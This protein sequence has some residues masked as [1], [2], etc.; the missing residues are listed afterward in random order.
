MRIRDTLVWAA[1][2]AAFGTVLAPAAPISAEPAHA[3]RTVGK[4]AREVDRRLASE[5]HK[6][7]ADLAPAAADAT[8]LRRV[9]LDTVGD[10]PSPEHATAFV[11]DPDPK[12]RERVLAELVAN[13]QFGHN[14]ARY[15]RDVVL[16]RRVEERAVLAADSVTAWLTEEINEGS[17]WDKVARDFITC[18]GDVRE[19]GATAIV[20][21]QDGRTEETTA[22]IARIFLG[23]QIQCAQCH[24]H[25]YDRWSRE[26]FHELAAFFPRTTLRQVVS[27]TKRSFEVGFND[28]PRIR[29]KG[30]NANRTGAPE[31][32]M[33][34]LDDPQAPGTRMQPKFFL[35]G[36]EL[37]FGTSDAA[38]RGTAAELITK[39]PWFAKAMVNRMWAELVGEG[40]YEPVDDIGPDREASAPET[41]DYLAEQFAANDYDL[42]WLVQVIASTD[43]YGRESRPR[44]LP[45]DV[46]FTANVVQ[47]LRADQ[48]FNS[49]LSALSISETDRVPFD[50]KN[51]AAK[52]YGARI[53]PRLIFNAAFGYDPSEPRESVSGSIPQALALMNTPQL[54]VAMS[55]GSRLRTTALGKMIASID[56]DEQ[57][58]TELYL[59]TLSREPSDSE[60]A[61]ALAYGES[62]G[63][64]SEAAE[65]LLWALIN[66][67]EFSHRR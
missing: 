55:A 3:E 9:W 52:A 15:F 22:E 29:G 26:D 39:S 7:T 38:R 4:T 28:N 8:W 20:F 16:Y 1:I 65:D 33:P 37:D 57:L 54:N 31:H 27:A 19:N 14:W 23:I 18:T 6:N 63:D 61:D 36:T 21:A 59:K 13:P 46:P 11:L 45:D 62:V 64:R 41:I 35:T 56:D 2:I 12:K 42:K 24:D 25:P 5:L 53:T 44:R 10:I 49:L 47:P 60:L 17:G 32:Y 34:D 48:L 43:A 51:E 58:V 66:S 50:F 40:F 67:S 30:D